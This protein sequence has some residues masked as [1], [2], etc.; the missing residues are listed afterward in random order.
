M[1]IDRLGTIVAAA[2]VL[3]LVGCMSG[4]L[5]R[6]NPFDPGAQYSVELVGVPD[7]VNSVSE[8]FT[9]AYQSDPELPPAPLF[10]TWTAAGPGAL[11]SA[12]GGAYYVSNL[13]TAEPRPATIRA[14]FGDR[15]VERTVI[16]RQRVDEIGVRCVTAGCD[17]LRSL[18]QAFTAY[19]DLADAG[20]TVV[21]GRAHA[22]ARGA[23]SIRDTT[24][25][26]RVLPDDEPG[27]VRFASAGNGVTWVVVQ[28]DRGLDS[29]RVVVRQQAQQWTHACP[30]SVQ[31][32]TTA[33]LSI[34]DPLDAR[35]VPLA[36]PVGM[37]TWDAGYDRWAGSPLAGGVATVDPAGN[38][39]AEAPGTWVTQA[40]VQGA[41]APYG[42]CI[43]E[44]VP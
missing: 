32:G 9:V 36:I 34:T 20:G 11:V 39:T 10:V 1:R 28:I 4:P 16:V 18:G 37:V 8:W 35:G 25:L 27:Q 23:I 6:R 13:A 43:I 38:I 26:R 21:A 14:A 42:S 22:F 41:F 7:T 24:V 30:T 12:G 15:V 17:S 40:I 31:V 5:E 33:R 44:L 3:M 2:T 29:L 19:V